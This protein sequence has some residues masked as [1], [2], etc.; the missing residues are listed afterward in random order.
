MKYGEPISSDEDLIPE[1][2]RQE[3]RRLVSVDYDDV[4][5]SMLAYIIMRGP[6]TLYRVSRETPYSISSI[7]KKAKYMVKNNL[8]LAKESNDRLNGKHVYDV[9]V[10]GLLACL[11]YRCLDDN[12]V[13]SKLRIKWNLRNYDNHKLVSILM[14]LPYVVKGESLRL[15]ENIDTL[16]ITTLSALVNDSTIGNKLIDEITITNVKNVSIYYLVNSIISNTS[17][18]K[19]PDIILGNS[20]FLVGY[21]KDSKMLYIYLCR[22]CEKNCALTYSSCDNR[23]R[24]INELSRDISNLVK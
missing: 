23:C 13:L 15:I 14:I 12:I 11:A 8:I 10:K 7:Y 22:L 18:I 19:R 3:L 21:Y 1:S 9:T 5:N 4:M 17:N 16:M 20:S 2:L 6:V 24:L